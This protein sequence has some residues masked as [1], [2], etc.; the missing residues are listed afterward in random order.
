[1][2]DSDEIIDD[3]L[4]LFEV[5]IR[6]ESA[7]YDDLLLRDIRAAGIDVRE[8]QRVRVR[9]GFWGEYTSLWF[10]RPTAR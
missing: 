1:V 4:A 5:P 2:V 9:E 8:G 3:A 7:G 6:E 10:R